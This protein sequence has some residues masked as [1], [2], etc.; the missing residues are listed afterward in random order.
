MRSTRDRL[1]ELRLLEAD[2]DLRDKLRGLEKH[3]DD[4][5][6][7]REAWKLAQRQ[8]LDLVL[9][10]HAGSKE[11]GRAIIANVASHVTISTVDMKTGRESGTKFGLSAGE[12]ADMRAQYPH[13]MDS[14][15]LSVSTAPKS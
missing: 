4:L 14:Q 13:N 6:L 3:F 5:N 11:V 7:W 2:I 9:H 15:K 10:I 12:L 1:H 8:G